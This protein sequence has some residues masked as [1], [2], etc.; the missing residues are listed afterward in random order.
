VVGGKDNFTGANA[1]VGLVALL[2]MEHTKYTPGSGQPG[3]VAVTEYTPGHIVL[4]VNAAHTSLLVVAE[5]YYP[6]WRATIDGQPATILRANYLSQGLVMSQ[7]KHTVEF[8]YEPDSFRNGAL[9]SLAGLASLL[10]LGA[11]TLLARK[12]AS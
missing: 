12:V 2:G 3:S 7:G 8:S 1:Y 4:N 5:S 6:G 9:I 11:W 10:A